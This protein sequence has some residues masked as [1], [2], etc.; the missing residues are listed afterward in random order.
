[1]KAGSKRSY[2]IFKQTFISSL[3]ASLTISHDNFS[4]FHAE[5]KTYK[6]MLEDNVE[7]YR[8]EQEEKNKNLEKISEKQLKTEKKEFKKKK[9]NKEESKELSITNYWE[10]DEIVP[11]WFSQIYDKILEGEF[12]ES[13]RR[14]EG[15]IDF[16]SLAKDHNIICF[17]L[18]Y[19]TEWYPE[20]IDYEAFKRYIKHNTIEKK[21]EVQNS[22]LDGSTIKLKVIKSFEY[23]AIVLSLE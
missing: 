19:E 3:S 18:G 14:I 9:L 7:K 13:L 8:I 6:S 23:I 2:S 15:N 17:Y 16:G 11:K 5:G 1:M 21:I 4:H 22:K 12:D 20:R 10:I